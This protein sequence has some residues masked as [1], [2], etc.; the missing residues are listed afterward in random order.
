[1]NASATASTCTPASG[2][3]DATR[4]SGALR[5]QRVM[6][7][8]PAR[9][10]GPSKPATFQPA[11]GYTIIPAG[12]PVDSYFQRDPNRPVPSRT[13]NRSEIL[14]WQCGEVAHDSLDCT[15][16]S[17]TGWERYYLRYLFPRSR[18][19]AGNPQQS[20]PGGLDSNFTGMEYRQPSAQT[21]ADEADIISD[22][23]R[24]SQ[25][26]GTLSDSEDDAPTPTSTDDEDS[27]EDDAPTPM[28][29]DDEDPYLPA[30]TFIADMA[31]YIEHV[32]PD[33]P[34]AELISLI[35]EVGPSRKRQ[36]TGTHVPITSLLKIESDDDMVHKSVHT[37]ERRPIAQPHSR[38]GKEKAVLPTADDAP[39]PSRPFD[40]QYGVAQ[41]GQLIWPDRPILHRSPTYW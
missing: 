27:G 24:A 15:S 1:M 17:L 21:I 3:S 36:G 9:L 38:K 41:D 6:A 13:L 12:E 34:V 5:N 33:K 10:G 18:N 2:L 20:G 16:P 4:Y 29:T 40:S 11:P 23:A 14:C 8:P 19:S 39:P 37:S 35:S 22:G 31:G 30:G 32:D 25:M 28:S 26:S 7:S